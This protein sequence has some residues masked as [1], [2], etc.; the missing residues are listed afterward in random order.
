MNWTLYRGDG[1][2][3]FNINFCAC[4]RGLGDDDDDICVLYFVGIFF[5]LKNI[6]NI[7]HHK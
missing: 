2:S 4:I 1:D 6:N 7:F 5:G 3:L